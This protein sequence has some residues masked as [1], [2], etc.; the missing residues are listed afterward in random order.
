MGERRDKKIQ[1]A[2]HV[3]QPVAMVVQDITMHLH[4]P[5]KEAVRLILLVAADD[6]PTLNRLAPYF[7]RSLQRGETMWIGHTEHA[8]LQQLIAPKGYSVE[9]VFTRMTRRETEPIADISFALASPLSHA[10]AALLTLATQD[11]RLLQ[12]VAPQFQ[13]R[14]PYSLREG[15]YLWGSG[16]KR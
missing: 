4:I 6:V 7:W 11:I 10:G 2:P 3:L 5:S 8:D 14:S 9:R 15:S 16:E 13:F 1:L 12:K